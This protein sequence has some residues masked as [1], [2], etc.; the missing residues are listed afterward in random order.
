[1][2]LSAEVIKISIRWLKTVPHV[3]LL[4]CPLH[5]V[6]FSADLSRKISSQLVPDFWGHVD[7][8]SLPGVVTHAQPVRKRREEPPTAHGQPESHCK[9]HQTCSPVVSM[10]SHD[11]AM[12]PFAID[13]LL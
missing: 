13:C 1:M 4:N 11:Q 2:L 7:V 9:I 6:E 3:L 10:S 12:W 5:G 8:C